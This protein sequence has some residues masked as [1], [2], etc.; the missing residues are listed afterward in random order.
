MRRANEQLERAGKN[1]GNSH[2]PPSSDSL[3][4]RKKRKKK[5]RS[6]RG[7]GAQPGHKKHERRL[8]DEHELDAIHDH[9]PSGSC[10]C[11]GDVRINDEPV[12]HQVFDV[13]PIRGVAA[14]HRLH[15]GRCCGCGKRHVG[16]LP[17]GVPSGQMGPGLVALISVLSGQYHLSTRKIQRLLGE[18]LGIGFSLGA[19]SEAQGKA[20]DAMA[21][22]YLDIGRHVR[23]QPIVNADETRHF[24]GDQLF[25]LWVLACPEAA[26]FVSHP[27]RGKDACDE[28]LGDTLATIVTDDYVGYDRIPPARRQLCWAHLLRHFIAVSERSGNAG[29]VGA[30]LVGVAE[31]LFALRRQLNASPAL[32]TDIWR[33]ASGALRV[34]CRAALERGARLRL[35][36]RTRTQC[37]RW[38]VREPMLWTHLG[39]PAIPIDNNAAERALRPYVIWR[40]L[41]YAVQSHRGNQFRPMVL[42]IVATAERLGLN[43]Y[44]YLRT[45]VAEQG[46]FG[47]VRTLLPMA[48]PALPAPA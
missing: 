11:G 4:R 20:I 17:P 36:G 21:D 14:E 7:Q 28:L 48:V 24:R 34:R 8:F 6:E 2:L 40:K 45:V 3:A 44:H 22:P 9:Y 13:P 43:A 31:A 23:A 5:T 10:G 1:S 47:S 41:S 26:W 19:V 33:A 29:D 35:D 18:I 16:A 39:D 32:D 12:R 38:L 15:R 42:S 30:E 25:W 37:R 27:S 46:R